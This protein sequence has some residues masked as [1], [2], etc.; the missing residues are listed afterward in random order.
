MVQGQAERGFSARR[1]P[2]TSLLSTA[3]DQD[4]GEQN[5]A[6]VQEGEALGADARERQRLPP[7]LG[8]RR[9]AG[10]ERRKQWAQ[11][12]PGGL[13]G[14][15]GQRPVSTALPFPLCISS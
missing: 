13:P 11:R 7:G 15:L 5:A 1:P 2:S 9:R 12:A 4:P 3:G 14:C 10:P 6:A 8:A